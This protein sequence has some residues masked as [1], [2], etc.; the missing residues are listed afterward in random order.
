MVTYEN[1]LLLRGKDGAPIPYVIPPRTLLIESPA[2][3]VD[4]SV[5]SHAQ[6]QGRRGVPGIPV[7]SARGQAILADYGFRP[8]KEGVPPPSSAQPLPPR[9]FTM[10]ELG[11]WAKIEQ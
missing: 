10:D 9:L 8:V 1:E 5:D 2:A 3:I 4:D 6:P 7:R 11:G